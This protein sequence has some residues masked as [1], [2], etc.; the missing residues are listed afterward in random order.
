MTSLI[1]REPELKQTRRQLRRY[2]R[3]SAYLESLIVLAGIAV[4]SL[5]AI[6]LANQVWPSSGPTRGMELLPMLTGEEEGA[7]GDDPE[8]GEN[9][10]PNPDQQPMRDEDLNSEDT[11]ITQVLSSVLS[12]ISPNELDLSDPSQRT[13]P[14]GS[15][16][17]GRPGGQGKEGTG[18]GRGG[19][20]S[21][22]RW[23]IRYPSQS[24]AEYAAVLDQFGIELGIIRGRDVTIV[25]GFSKG[26]PIVQK[27]NAT[28]DRLFFQWQ[29]APRRKADID[30]LRTRGIAVGNGI[31]VQFFPQTLERLLA[32]LE[33]AQ[34]RVPI[35]RIRKTR[36]GVRPTADKRFEF[37][38][39]EIVTMN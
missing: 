25:K 30:L 32:D 7:A 20:P 39:A 12:E 23:D 26:Q 2:D 11:E 22:A 9:S 10:I 18:T 13:G 31:V 4:L 37:Y 21:F 14:K 38:V 5:A 16:T 27:A 15:G 34:A 19:I 36:F 3:V 17:P 29:D 35:E 1:D 6:W 8:L 24:V 33:R 28:D